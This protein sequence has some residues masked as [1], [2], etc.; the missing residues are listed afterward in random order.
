ML[1]TNPQELDNYTN[2][3]AVVLKPTI[4]GGIE[5]AMQF[6]RKAKSLGLAAVIS[7]S[8]ESSLGILTLAHLAAAISGK[9]TPVGLDTL[10]WLEHDLLLEPI[11]YAH[12]RMRIL[13][14]AQVASQVNESSLK[15][16]S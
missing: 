12:G 4:L 14:I 1:K 11:D 5:R 9:D 15:E 8:F 3:A 16:I 13:Q 10:S 7:S 2:I 6:A